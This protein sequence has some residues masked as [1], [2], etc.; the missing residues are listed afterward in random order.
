MGNFIHVKSAEFLLIFLKWTVN[1]GNHTM[2]LLK[3][4]VI[5]PLTSFKFIGAA[6]TKQANC[7]L[8]LL[9][10]NFCFILI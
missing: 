2:E 1:N 6:K 9:G 4:A 10:L 7:K 8:L 3:Q 5:L